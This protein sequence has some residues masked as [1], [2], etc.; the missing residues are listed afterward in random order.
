MSSGRPPRLAILLQ[1]WFGLAHDE[2]FTGDL[3]EEFHSGRSAGWFWRQTLAAILAG[4][5]RVAHRSDA[6]PLFVA[7]GVVTGVTV[8]FLLIHG[9]V[10]IQPSVKSVL[11]LVLFWVLW[12]V[13]V[14]DRF[15][16]KGYWGKLLVVSG[17]LM[18]D[19][20]TWI[21]VCGLAGGDLCSAAYMVW[22]NLLW[23]AID[24][25]RLLIKK[26]AKRSPQNG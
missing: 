24:F 26:P 11:S 13:L 16:P 7:H 1:K 25:W 18:Q 5:R 9:R 3:I 6:L 23:F 15:K 2:A 8:S 14:H 10:R 21:A 12:V 4:I 20:A 19:N 22:I 17:R